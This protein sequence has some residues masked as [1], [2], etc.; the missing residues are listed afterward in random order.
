M[1]S[2]PI[3]SDI[4]TARI[5]SCK[6]RARHFPYTN[7]P[8]ALA[9]AAASVAEQEPARTIS[10]SIG[11]LFKHSVFPPLF[12]SLLH[13]KCHLSGLRRKKMRCKCPYAQHTC[14]TCRMKKLSARALSMYSCFA[15][16]SSLAQQNPSPRSHCNQQAQRPP[17]MVH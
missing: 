7:V 12:S 3:A 9:T 5:A 4:R 13:T 11:W 2:P 6:L 17:H 14:L 16:T 10:S 15:T 1:C 8:G